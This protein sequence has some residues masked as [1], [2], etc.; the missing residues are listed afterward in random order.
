MENMKFYASNNYKVIMATTGWY[1]NL[2]EVKEMFK[3][4]S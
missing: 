2:D 1:D 4:S 3:N